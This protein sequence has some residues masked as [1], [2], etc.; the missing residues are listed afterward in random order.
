ML[1]RRQRVHEMRAS[2]LHSRHP[3]RRRPRRLQWD[4]SQSWTM[5]VT[6]WHTPEGIE[7]VRRVCFCTPSD[8][9]TIADQKPA[10]LV[11]SCG[12]RLRTLPARNTAVTFH[13][14]FRMLCTKT[15]AL[16]ARFGARRRE[17][18]L[19]AAMSMNM[20]LQIMSV[21]IPSSTPATRVICA[22]AVS[23][24]LG[25][26]AVHSIPARTSR[27]E[28]QAVAVSGHVRNGPVRRV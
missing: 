27:A 5:K 1:A 16:C 10:S 25:Q 12:K 22:S 3:H 14:P 13:F 26:D 2:L 4:Q 7:L 11:S 23:R 18:I 15:R 24:N 6:K 9:N 21:A 28:P 20:A 19:H 17:T 8:Q